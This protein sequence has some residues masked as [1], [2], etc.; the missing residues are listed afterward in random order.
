MATVVRIINGI[1]RIQTESSSPVI[2]DEVFQILSPVSTG[3][4]VTLP[5]GKTYVGDE[6]KVKFRGQDLSDV[7]DYNW[8]GTGSKTQVVFTFDLQVGDY[9]G[10]RIDRAP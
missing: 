3:T 7:Y 1:P 9:I 10:F 8:V 4:P 6:L 2:Y 5:N